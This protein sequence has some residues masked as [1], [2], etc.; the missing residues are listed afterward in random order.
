MLFTAPYIVWLI[1]TSEFMPL[2]L[3]RKHEH[4]DYPF[5]LANSPNF[6]YM[7]AKWRPTY[8]AGPLEH[9]FTGVDWIFS[10]QP[11]NM[12]ILFFLQMQTWVWICKSKSAFLNDSPFPCSIVRCMWH[13]GEKGEDANLATYNKFI[14]MIWT[15][16][17]NSGHAKTMYRRS[18]MQISS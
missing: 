9:K 1:Y 2:T 16:L 15:M 13:H 8:L 17:I 11:E 6:P 7:P 3:Y 4:I 5:I 18:D 10:L 14:C 12:G